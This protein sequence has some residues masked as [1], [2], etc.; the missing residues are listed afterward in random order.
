M[1]ENF[2]NSELLLQYLDGE[3]QGDQ[4][5]A[6]K[7]S[8]DEN[9]SI[10]EELEKLQMAK[11]A[12]KSYALKNKIGSIHI[13]MMQEF[14]RKGT[15][16]TG[17]TRKLFPQS[18]RIAAIIIILVGVPVLYQYFTATPEILFS[19]NFHPFA[20]HE[21]R[22][23][24]GSSL[25]KAYKNERMDAVIQEFNQLQDPQPE[26]FFLAGNAFLRSQQP[27][28]AIQAFVE[29]QVRNKI[30][31]KQYFEEDAEYYLALSYLDNNEPVKALPIFEKI[32]ADENHQYNKKVS[33][34]FLRK[35]R[36]LGST[37]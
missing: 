4:L 29:L 5:Y 32:H 10:S 1:S 15:F 7:K 18:L 19:E 34:W 11:E 2:T 9:P 20:L 13:E 16:K 36:R 3:L 6:I 27:A 12:F 33:F 30:E 24:S 14:K 28:K 31:N 35:V 21:T 26:D 17:I 23:K 8:I 22:G 25:E 37:K